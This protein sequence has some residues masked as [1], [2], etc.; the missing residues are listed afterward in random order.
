MSMQAPTH[1]GFKLKYQ[2]GK[3][4]WAQLARGEKQMIDLTPGEQ[5]SV[6]KAIGDMADLMEE[7]GWETR[8]CDLKGEQVQQLVTCV[9]GSYQDSELARISKPAA[10]DPLD[11]DIPF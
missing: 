8:F 4:L 9:I 10:E 2:P 1:Q 5:E 11:D 6:N 7:I 3:G